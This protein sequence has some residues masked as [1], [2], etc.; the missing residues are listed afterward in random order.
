MKD[1]E[2]EKDCDR[3]LN[4][5]RLPQPVLLGIREDQNSQEVFRESNLLRPAGLEPRTF[6]SWMREE[7][8]EKCSNYLGEVEA[9][10]F[11]LLRLATVT[12]ASRFAHAYIKYRR[13]IR[14]DRL[15]FPGR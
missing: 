14:T 8:V 3:T 2:Y 6:G 11:R 1:D 4:R 15:P 12:D 7:S 13:M 10:L 9:T 5:Y